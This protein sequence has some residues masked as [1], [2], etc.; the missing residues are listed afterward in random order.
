MDGFMLATVMIGTVSVLYEL[1]QRTTLDDD[2]V[3]STP[4]WVWGT[5]ILAVFFSYL[6]YLGMFRAVVLVDEEI[7]P[8]Y[9][10]YRKFTGPEYKIHAKAINPIVT[11]LTPLRVPSSCNS[12]RP[13]PIQ[14]RFCPRHA[15]LQRAHVPG[16]GGRAGEV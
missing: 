2:L 4:F 5:G 1:A 11:L 6:G 16:W 7:G 14:A 13:R 15:P 8:F 12:L 3:A 9:F 10:I